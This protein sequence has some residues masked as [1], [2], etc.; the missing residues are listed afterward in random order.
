MLLREYITGLMGHPLTSGYVPDPLLLVRGQGLQQTQRLGPR[1]S[2]EKPHNQLQLA[3][4]EAHGHFLG[5]PRDRR[6]S[7]RLRPP[8]GDVREGVGEELGRRV[9]LPPLSPRTTAAHRLEFPQF[10]ALIVSIMK[11]AHQEWRDILGNEKAPVS[12]QER[13]SFVMPG[14]RDPGGE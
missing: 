14:D 7:G 5:R 8:C 3:R 9:R 12:R 13:G 6:L 1:I 10:H 2:R 4:S 11:S